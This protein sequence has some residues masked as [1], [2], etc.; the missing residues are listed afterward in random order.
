M[1]KDFNQIDYCSPV[2]DG[3]I[4]IIKLLRLILKNQLLTNATTGVGRAIPKI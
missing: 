1:A 3:T 4:W 2:K